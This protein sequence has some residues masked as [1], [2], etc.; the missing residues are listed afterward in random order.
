M[1][2]ENYITTIAITITTTDVADAAAIV[3][4]YG[5]RHSMFYEVEEKRH[6]K[7]RQMPQVTEVQLIPTHLDRGKDIYNFD[8]DNKIRT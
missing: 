6:D 3:A 2:R 5:H 8:F 7:V 1:A 4:G